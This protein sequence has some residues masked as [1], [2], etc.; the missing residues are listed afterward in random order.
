MVE[1]IFLENNVKVDRKGC[2]PYPRE[3]K[4][5]FLKMLKNI[6]AECTFLY[7]IKGYNFFLGKKVKNIHKILRKKVNL[8]NCSYKIF[9]RSKN[10]RIFL[11]I[12]LNKI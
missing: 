11:K 1:G 2:L 6:S 9:R 8:V 3:C 5:Y 4:F 12:Y 10:L 7:L